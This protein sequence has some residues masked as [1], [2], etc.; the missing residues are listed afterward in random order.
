[1]SPARFNHNG[2]TVNSQ[3]CQPLVERTGEAKPQRG[4]SALAFV[5]SDL[6]A[7]A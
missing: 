2:V 6:V 5:P 1:M 3:G 4:D 7:A